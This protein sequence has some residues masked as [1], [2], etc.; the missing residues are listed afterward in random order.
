[1]SIF[2]QEIYI[3]YMAAMSTVHMTWSLKDIN[4]KAHSV[5]QSELVKGTTKPV[6][7]S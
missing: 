2:I 6:S 5:I 3:G 7:Y 4:K 1:M